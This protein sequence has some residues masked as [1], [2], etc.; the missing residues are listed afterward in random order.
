MCGQQRARGSYQRVGSRGNVNNQSDAGGS[1]LA[2]Q[3]QTREDRNLKVG[4]EARK[5]WQEIRERV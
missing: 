4:R 3:E 1:D 5:R 2:G